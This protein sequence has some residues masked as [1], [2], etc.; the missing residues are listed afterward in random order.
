MKQTRHIIIPY[1][2]IVEVGDVAKFTSIENRSPVR[3]LFYLSDT[4]PTREQM[5]K[6]H[7]LGSEKDNLTDKKQSIESGDKVWVGNLYLNA[8]KSNVTIAYTE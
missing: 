1:G 6:G 2:D 7:T 4:K 5:Q 3:C 8:L